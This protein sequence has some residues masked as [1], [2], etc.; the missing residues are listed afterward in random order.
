MTTPM[1]MQWLAK[2]FG[3]RRH[4][5]EPR[6]VKTFAAESR[7]TLLQARVGEFTLACGHP[8]YVVAVYAFNDPKDKWIQIGMF[9]ED[10]VEVIL[11][12]LLDA[13]SHIGGLY[14]NYREGDKEV[15]TAD[16]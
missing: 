3:F 13:E 6:V 7:E 15:C 10:D 11:D 8:T 1:C 14:A 5:C 2:L 9:H 16:C 12:L 4:V